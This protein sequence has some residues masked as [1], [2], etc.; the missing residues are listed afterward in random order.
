MCAALLASIVF[1]VPAGVP[2]AAAKPPKGAC[3]N[4]EPARPV[5]RQL[6]WAQQYLDPERAWPFSTGAGVTVAVVDSGVDADHPQLRRKGKVLRGRDFFL[7]GRLPGNYDCVSHGTGVASIIAGDKLDRIGFHGVAPNARILP[8]RISD[9]E[10]TDNGDTRV[11]DPNVLARGIRYAADQG[12]KVINLSLSGL[13]D[14]KQVRAA[15]QYAQKKDV[16]IVAAVG[17]AQGENDGAPDLPSYPAAYEGVLGVGAIDIAGARSNNSQIGRYVDLV[18]PGDGVLTATR[19]AGHQYV[20]G[21]SFAAP[22]VSGTAALVRSAWPELTAQQVTQR[23]LATATPARGGPGSLAYGAGVV[24]P[25]RAVT[26]GM[27]GRTPAAVPDA[28]R[29]TPDPAVVAEAAWWDDAG[30]HARTIGLLTLGGAAMAGLLGIAL[31]LGRRRRWRPA[32]AEVD[33]KRPRADEPPP[34]ELF[35][36][37]PSRKQSNDQPDDPFVLPPGLLDP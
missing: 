2:S 33:Q 26:E 14:H 19:Q 28:E 3:T 1:V 34:E 11:I 6:P 17:N 20:R 35:Q 9:R 21:T 10:M 15:I 37:T 18:A 24:D 7:V 12:A 27:G 30:T 8:V 29:T 23:L 16:L 32:R 31:V 36:T 4:P 25:Y 5:V 13:R 22:F